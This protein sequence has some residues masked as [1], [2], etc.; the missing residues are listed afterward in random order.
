MTQGRVNIEILPTGAVVPHNQTLDAV[1]SGILQGH[2]T[3]PSYFSGIDPAFSMLGNLVGAWGDPLEFLEYMKYGGGEELYN[4]LVEPY[5]VHLIGAAATGL[6]A[7][8]TKKPIRT[9]CR[10]EG[11]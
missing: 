11:P 4:E 2:L 6:E 8:V 10:L 3:D 9:V 7:F 5:N 1:R